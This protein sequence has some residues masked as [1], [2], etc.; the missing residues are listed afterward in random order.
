MVNYYLR[1]LSPYAQKEGKNIILT[2]LHR[3]MSHLLETASSRTFH[4]SQMY[5]MFMPH[6]YAF[7]C[8]Q[9]S[10]T[11]A[12]ATGHM[13]GGGFALSSEVAAFVEDN[14]GVVNVQKADVG[15]KE[16]VDKALTVRALCLLLQTPVSLTTP[17]VH[18]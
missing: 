18:C 3:Q 12:A 8:T 14:C 7:L 10:D 5:E 15:F 16:S 2:G 11:A 13:G 9:L 17:Q 1:V 6:T 4:P